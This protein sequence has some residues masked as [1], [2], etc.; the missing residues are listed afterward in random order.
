MSFT[1]KCFGILK[2]QLQKNIFNV[3][4]PVGLMLGLW[5]DL[6]LCRTV[7]VYLDTYTK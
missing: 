3:D 2:L 5:L 6:L 7:F 4:I 1:D